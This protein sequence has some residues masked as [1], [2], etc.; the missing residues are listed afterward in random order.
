MHPVSLFL[1]VD[2]SPSLLEHSI[3]LPEAQERQSLAQAVQV[4][5][6]RMDMD[7]HTVLVDIQLFASQG[8]HIEA[9]WLVH[10]QKVAGDSWASYSFAADTADRKR[11]EADNAYHHRLAFLSDSGHNETAVPVLEGA[12]AAPE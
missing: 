9:Q 11:G 8:T 1:S 5:A 3:Q 12:V 6:W 7:K 4:L 2:Y 10:R